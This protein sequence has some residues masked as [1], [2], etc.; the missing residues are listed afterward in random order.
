LLKY[1]TTGAILFGDMGNNRY[2]IPLTYPDDEVLKR[3]GI[4]LANATLRAL[5]T[6]EPIDP[7]ILRAMSIAPG[8]PS[9]TPDGSTDIPAQNGRRERKLMPVPDDPT[10]KAF[11]EGLNTTIPGLSQYPNLIFAP[12]IL[13]KPGFDY[14]DTDLQHLREVFPEAIRV[15]PVTARLIIPSVDQSIQGVVR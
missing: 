15:V 3:R 7:P 1:L 9:W 4:K 14:R 12:I 2:E 6:G 8:E 13:G 5:I 10:N 11:A